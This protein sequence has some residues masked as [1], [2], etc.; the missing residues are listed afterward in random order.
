MTTISLLNEHPL[1]ASLKHWYARPGDRLEAAL[2]G[3]I[4]DILRG[5][6][7]IEIQTGSFAAIRR[8]VRA[9][10]RHYHVTLVYP[11]AH[12]R[13]ILTLPLARVLGQSR[14]FAQKVAYCLRESG[15]STAI[16]KAGNAIVYSRT[17][18]TDSP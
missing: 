11:V 1:H 8:K 7:I 13:W 9:L 3:Y 16:G 2:D 18:S 5:N 12:E 10:S 15:A 6:H 4:V 14:W 17:P